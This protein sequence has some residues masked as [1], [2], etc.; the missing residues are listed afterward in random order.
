MSFA[1][2]PPAAELLRLPRQSAGF[3]CS[4]SLP[5]RAGADVAVSGLFT[6]VFTP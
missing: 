3:G 6:V 2:H 1:S 4:R 5:A